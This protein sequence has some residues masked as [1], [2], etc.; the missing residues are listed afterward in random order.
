VASPD[1]AAPHFGGDHGE[2]GQ[3]R[4]RRRS[5]GF[6]RQG[7]SQGISTPAPEPALRLGTQ[8]QSIGLSGES[9]GCSDVVDFPE[10]NPLDHVEVRV[11]AERRPVPPRR[12]PQPAPPSEQPLRTPMQAWPVY[13]PFAARRRR[14]PEWVVAYVSA[15]VVGD[16]LA[17]TVAL[18]LAARLPVVGS[19][20]TLPVIGVVMLTWPLLLVA[21]GTYVERRQGTGMDEYRRVAL[22]GV[23]AVALSGVVAA[24]VQRDLDALVLVAAPAA[25]L[26][27]FAGRL[28]NRHRLHTAR[29][30]GQMT[31]RVVVVGRETAVID[32]V[33]RLRRDTAAGLRVIGA[34]VPAP[35]HSSR[36]VA[37]GIPVLGALDEVVRIL[38]DA[39]ADTVLVASASESAAH[40]LRDLAWRLEGTN[41][42]LLVAPG[43][44]EVA[45]NR[46]QVRP[47]TSAPL[48]Q[49]RE[50][51]YRGHRR[52]VKK[53]A[54]RLA[55]AALLLLLLPVLVMIA[56][57]VRL[58]SPG[59]AFYRHRR[60]GQHGR[61][62]DLLKFRSM[63]DGAEA[64]IDA[65]MEH[66][67]GNLVQFK[68]RRD[69]RVT[70]V[71]RV[72]RRYSLDELPQLINVLKGEMSLVGPRPHVAR[73]VQQYGPDMHR[74]LLVPPGI[75]GLWQ[76]SGRSNLSWDESVEL[77]VRY[78]ENWSLVLDLTILWRTFRA[79]VRA[80]GAY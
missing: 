74:R 67:E 62:F 21:S 34:C 77:D 17:V 41:I 10:R 45:P 58:T 40:Y 6:R 60:V 22:A 18:A 47:I 9:D 25:A 3:A 78:V 69:P 49:I 44:I 68:M 50:P 43:M 19:Q 64:A 24:V 46:L 59:P 75:T 26:L 57:A 8:S 33:Q 63:T 7:L 20:V 32:L 5:I 66:N 1:S 31:K 11:L 53:A 70:A 28:L 2:T 52:V 72:L 61:D 79:V 14:A 39:R 30:N 27:T 73:E 38:D 12:A 65:L 37:S 48:I 54:D 42:E 71:G 35:M 51:E 56:V 55:A 23:L 15:L 16:V 80:A 36:L 13:D 29:R 76:V 4:A